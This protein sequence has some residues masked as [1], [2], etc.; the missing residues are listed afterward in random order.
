MYT[1]SAYF[2]KVSVKIHATEKNKIIVYMYYWCNLNFL[3]RV[4]KR[5]LNFSLTLF[6]S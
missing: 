4:K 6:P 5:D 2:C 1:C 3:E